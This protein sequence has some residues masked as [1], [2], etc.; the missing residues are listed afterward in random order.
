MDIGLLVNITARA[1]SLAILAA[2]HR[3]VPGRQTALLQ[4]VGAGRAAFGQSLGHLV[5]LG[6]VER[7][8]GH[9]HPL[10]PE[11]RLTP[12]GVVAARLADGVLRVSQGG[13]VRRAWVVPVLGLSRLPCRFTQLRAGLGPVTDRALSQTLQALQAERWIDRRIDPQDWPARP[14][15]V[16]A[17]DGARIAAVLAPQLTP[18]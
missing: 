8:P 15:Y 14:V 5:A 11:Y 1:W 2:F 16:A 12:A 7:N 6:L 13:L 3:G 18:R 17:G 10:R 9:G 4:A